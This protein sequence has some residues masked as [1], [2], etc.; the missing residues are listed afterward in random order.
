MKT[1][2]LLTALLFTGCAHS[3]LYYTDGRKA[4]DLQS[5]LSGK[6]VLSKDRIEFAGTMDNSTPTLAQG[7]AFS[8]KATA[9][10]GAILTS[11]IMGALK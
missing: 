5:N 9:L 3:T 4:A 1:T 10:G 2:L 6:L 11:G 8:K 7:E